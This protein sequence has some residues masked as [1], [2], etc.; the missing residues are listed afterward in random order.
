MASYELYR[1]DVTL[2]KDYSGSDTRQVAAASCTIQLYRKGARLSAS[3]GGTVTGSQVMAA[4]DAGTIG[5]GDTVVVDTGSTTGTVTSIA[6]SS[7]T[8][9]WGANNISWSSGSRLIPTNRRPTAYSDSQG[10][11]SLGNSVTT[12]SSG[13]VAFYTRN[14]DIDLVAT[15]GSTS[16]VIADQSGMG[17]PQSL[18][19]F[20]WG[21]QIDGSTD[22]YAAFNNLL[23]YVSIKGGQEI[24]LPAGTMLVGT[25]ITPSS[26]V[27]I[28]GKGRGITYVQQSGNGGVFSLGSDMRIEAMTIKRSSAGS[29]SSVL[30]AFTAT[31]PVIRDV[32]FQ[33]GA[34]G[35]LDTAT[36]GTVND[37]VFTGGSWEKL[38]YC[39][40][41]TRTH[42]TSIRSRFTNDLGATDAAVYISDGCT[43]LRFLNC[44]VG[45]LSVA[46]GGN[47][48]TAVYLATAGGTA[49]KDVLF[50]GCRFAGGLKTATQR[51][52]VWIAAGK[53]IQFIGCTVED[54]LVGYDVDGGTD[55][56]VVGGSVLGCYK[57][58]FDVDGGTMFRIVEATSSDC[59]QAANN[60][61][62]HVDF[63]GTSDQ[64]YV[65]GLTVGNQVRGGVPEANYGVII[66]AAVT[67]AQLMGV[68]GNLTDLGTGWFLCSSTSADV[69]ISHNVESGGLAPVTYS[70]I[71]MQGSG[72]GVLTLTTTS[73]TPNVKNIGRIYLQQSGA[74]T[75]TELEGARDGQL[76]VL[77]AGN[78]N[79]T[80]NDGGNFALD[81]GANWTSGQHDTLTL[82]YNGTTNMWDEVSRSNN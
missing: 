6:A 75:I 19:P 7:V 3:S 49:T 62:A 50:S 12:D 61:Y 48:G 52:G 45:P 14:K 9:N 35:I 57:E 60:T 21:C 82:V 22:D 28:R 58:S 77:Y 67:I 24:Q 64:C 51:A 43:G 25:A 13:N 39:V 10:A 27:T 71:G 5:A 72:R 8:V 44:D 36:D 55:V 29:A 81:A 69:D 73:A 68:R 17:G 38:V 63:G 4:N 53:S 34:I 26:A 11:T 32:E 33:S 15:V 79:T 30:V 46:A 59:G 47:S 78:G 23:T 80:I 56:K 41:S 66:G 37:V 42:Y 76:V 18:N 1:Q 74:T 54:S 31:R 70:H 65:N 20:D 2:F 16:R 40:G